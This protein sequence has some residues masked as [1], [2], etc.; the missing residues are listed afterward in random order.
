MPEQKFCWG[1]LRRRE[2]VLPTWRGW[3]IIVTAL[4]VC[5]YGAVRGIHAFLSVN[6]PKPGGALVVEGWAAD[7]ALAEAAAEFKRNHYDKLYVTG[8]PIENGAPLSEFNTYAELAAA[9]LL[10]HGLST[11]EVQPIPA[12]PVAKDRTYTSAV[13]LREWFKGHGVW[14]A[15]VNLMTEGAH[16]RRSRLM[17]E[18]ALGPSVA[19]GVLNVPSQGYDP[20]HWWRSSQ[21]VRVELGESF[22]Y[23]YA[24]FLFHP[25]RP[26]K[27]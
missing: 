10:K 24:R 16:A 13:A 21:G 26:Q 25:S 12:P 1:T 18:K 15:T 14:P 2:L 22:A 9:V 20:R 6:D 23:F 7:Y 17:F 4:L 3:L 5:G 11:N 19:I 8:G 27:P